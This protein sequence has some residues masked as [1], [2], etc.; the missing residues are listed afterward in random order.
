MSSPDPAGPQDQGT[1]SNPDATYFARKLTLTN[2]AAFDNRV[3]EA[4][5]I[6]L[7]GNKIVLG[8]PGMGKSRLMEEL[9][10]K[11][12]VKPVTAIR[13]INSNNPERLITLGK[14]LIIDGLDEAM[15]RS[16]GDAIDAILSQLENANSPP[17][18]LSCRSREWQARSVSNLSQL[19]GADPQILSL[20]PLDRGEA[21]SFLSAQ[22]PT[23]NADEVL[24][25]L[26]GHSLEDLYRNPLTLG[27]MGR[28]AETDTQ[29][30]ATRAAL[31]KRVCELIWPEHDPDR[32]N[33]GLA[34][35][36][37]E[38]TLDAAG[39]IACGLLFA[40]AEAA[41]MAGAAQV[42]QG[43]L[44]IADL[45]KLPKAQAAR[46]IFSSK[47]FTGIGVSRAKPI[48]RVVAEYLGA[49]WLARQAITSRAQRRL[50]SQFHGSGGVPA[51]LRGLH[52][53][54][55]FHS[56]SMAERVIAEDPYGV[57]R[58]G[59]TDALT[60][61]L[62]DCLFESLCLLAQENPY[63]RA[64]DWDSKTA[65][66]LMITGLKD[67]INGI[68][69]SASAP[70][71]LRSLLIEGINGTQLAIALADTLES[72]L[73]SPERFY[74]ERHD[75]A[76]ALLPNRDRAFWRRTIAVLTDQGG[77]DA[78][79]LAKDLI[80][81]ID[82]DVTDTQIATTL[83][84]EMGLIS[85]PLQGRKG[86]Q[87]RTIRH[88][89]QLLNT[90]PAPRLI[91]LLTEIAEYSSLISKGDWEH[92]NDVADITA[93]LLVRAIDEDLVGPTDA[94]L[95]WRC[96]G[97]IEE[98]HRY[99]RN[100]K[101]TLA[102]RLAANDVLRRAIQEHALSQHR[103]KDSV[104]MTEMSLRYRLVPI[105]AQPGDLVAIF[106]RF[107]AGDLKDETLR[108]DWMDL[109]RLG[110]GPNGL[111]P[112]VRAAAEKFRRGDKQ[113]GDFL[114]KLENP[115]KAPWLIRQE[116]EE[117]NRARKRSVAFEIQRRE[118]EK[119]R[120]GL[121]AG[122]LRAILSTAQAYLGVF[123]DLS[124][125]ISPTERLA[126]WVGERLRDDALLGFEAVLH[127]SDLPTS[128]EIAD[129]FARGTIYNFGYPIMAGLYERIRSGKGISDL[130][131]SLKQ[132]ALLLC[133][134]DNGWNLEGE[135]DQVLAALETEVIPTLEA[136][137]AFARLWIEP[138]LAA[139]N[140]HVSGL[141]KL[142][143]DADWQATGAALAAEW[144]T[145][146]SS[147]P[148]PIEVGLVDCLT[149]GGA[150]D[151]LRIVADARSKSVFRNFDHLL[152]WLAID[153][154]VRFDA[155]K[156]DLAEIGVHHPD[157]LW[158]LRNR[159]RFERRGGM[160][161]VTV[162][163][164]EWIITEF[165]EQ[166]PHAVLRGSGSGDIN[167]YD[168]T[169]FLRSLIGRIANDTS[170]EAAAAMAR[171]IAGPKDSYAD[172]IRHMAAEQRQKRAEEDFSPLAPSN[173]AELLHDGPPGN[174]EDLKAVVREEMEVA[175][176]KL[177]GDDLDTVVE[178]WTDA[179]YP[180]DENRCRDRLA[181]LIGP[182]LARYDIQRITEAD[183]PQNKR[184]DLAFAHKA[185]QLP[186]EVKG[187]W[188]PNVWDAA[189]GQLDIQYLIDWRSEQRG[190]YCVLW[191][192]DVLAASGRRLRAH[193]DGLSA[194]KTAKEML[195][196]LI[197]RIP[198]SRRAHIDV[199]VLDFTAGANRAKTTK[200]L[201]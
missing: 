65:S 64:A 71:H 98:A 127:R 35:L 20:E 18:I 120:D 19:Y 159:L 116:R 192:G 184:A 132:A 112:S 142:A 28:V 13:F 172:L 157:F 169:E 180:R 118:L 150:L 76:E 117:A 86:D 80:Q 87:T 174:V 69:A 77:D 178:F 50:L 90:I 60:V 145:S 130:P 175:Q 51:S 52:A 44:R 59:E 70:A 63:F 96:L 113:L 17:F 2:A 151:A 78:P 106:D 110:W 1:S 3:D 104:L 10:R 133:Y 32:Q 22:H 57:L 122:E 89:G 27:L 148:E 55:A 6:A 131:Y 43:D 82:A 144:L 88:Y 189:A 160:L 30:P 166:W 195:N 68:I 91:S 5:L 109:V 168:A 162:A 177:I 121:R 73:L 79:R 185:M 115:K 34:Q 37:E 61:R 107:A 12:G 123:S 40:G 62:A 66:G 46:A 140:E 126:E 29:L 165:R 49:R 31:F 23:V 147:V 85:C 36:A 176:K 155:I 24:E 111:D 25:H 39:A 9:G 99:N 26:A 134:N 7:A 38:E 48:H 119:V 193:P 128:A 190:I 153:V 58:Y 201:K 136:R 95:L 173:L 72:V 198:E 41:S 135:Q 4:G 182:E 187:Q 139:G 54:L 138:A 152:S 179:G 156:P 93:H 14:P 102:H 84:A 67:K 194:P 149:Y 124:R 171:L 108:Q 92:E 33:E 167:D 45:E 188:H 94:P 191:F 158:F 53:W 143:H 196:M 11:L 16:E 200:P 105:S 114:R 183:M 164:A 101:K 186:M 197:Q 56:P 181:A 75:A 47:L 161:A 97:L 137:K 170:V 163:Q 74:S 42:Q 8:E 83:F 199:V 129:G 125:E 154:L 21:R 141:Y 146:F 100:E 15:S 81:R 103:R